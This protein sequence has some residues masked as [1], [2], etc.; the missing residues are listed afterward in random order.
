MLNYNDLIII[1]E[2]ILELLKPR[3]ERY[4]FPN[5]Y[6]SLGVESSEYFL[7]LEIR[8]S[9]LLGLGPRKIFLSFPGD[10]VLQPDLG[11]R[12]PVAG[13]SS[14]PPLREFC[15]LVSSI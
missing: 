6:Q 3:G 4:S 10:S 8:D 11:T 9:D 14:S 7:G 13:S 15:L 12:P 1:Q 2:I 5:G